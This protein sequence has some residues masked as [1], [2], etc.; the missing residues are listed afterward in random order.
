MKLKD[1][2]LLVVI[3]VLVLSVLILGYLYKNSKDEAHRQ[4]ANV[5]NLVKLHNQELILTR[6]EFSHVEA[7]WKAKVDSLVKALHLKINNVKTV[8]IINT[9]YRDTGS[10]IVVMK[11]PVLKPDKTFS[12]PFT[13]KDKCWGVAGQILTTDK[14]SKVRIDTKTFDN[15]SQLLVTRKRF[16]GF[17][18]WKKDEVF[19]AYT[20]CG[21][22]TFTK[23]TF[24]K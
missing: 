13:Y 16:L 17:L 8:T 22:I 11:E 19:K 5:E 6:N 1:K 23:I 2:I 12:V 10:V 4:T 9:E 15:S 24:V 20:D 18:W 21:E 7:K 3:T 14:N